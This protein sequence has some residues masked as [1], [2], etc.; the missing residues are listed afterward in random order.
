M[1]QMPPTSSFSNRRTRVLG[2]SIPF[3]PR[4]PSSAS[5]TSRLSLSVTVTLSMILRLP[6]SRIVDFTF[7]ASSGR[8]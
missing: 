8:T 5:Y 1:H 4:L 3:T 7:S 6:R 2:T